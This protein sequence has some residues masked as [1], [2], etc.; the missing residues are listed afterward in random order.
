MLFKLLLFVFLAYSLGASEQIKNIYLQSNYF[1]KNDFVMLSDIVKKPTKDVQLYKINPNRHTKRVKAKE[2]LKNLKKYG[3]K[4]FV[5]KH[6]YVQFSKKSPINSE[7]IKEQ[8]KK[9]YQK[10]YS[11]IEILSLQVEPRAYMEKLPR[12]YQFEIDDKEYLSNEGICS[13]KTQENKK[14]FFNY[15]ISAKI[16]VYKTRTMLKRGTELSN[17]NIQKKSIM[18]D[19]FRAAPIQT[20]SAH[21][22][23]AKH[24]LK[25][26]TILTQRDVTGLYLVKRGATV[27]VFLNDG[28]INISFTAKAV[29]NGRYG[30]KITVLRSDDKKIK[31]RVSGQN[32]AEM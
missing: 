8:I 1:V 9:E 25:A 28:G 31:V 17:M 24:R 5:S 3:Y 11:N 21:S 12:K 20:L 2:F 7:H 10:R 29:T 19:K 27:V 14:I 32:R 22:L 6:N 26:E 18:L 30:D 13:I 15:H 23:E 4:N 16:T